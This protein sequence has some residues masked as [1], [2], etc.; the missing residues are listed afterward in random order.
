MFI[1]SNDVS[2]CDVIELYSPRRYDNGQFADIAGLSTPYVVLQ[3]LYSWGSFTMLQVYTAILLAILSCSAV[4]HGFDPLPGSGM[5]PD[6]KQTQ[7]HKETTTTPQ[8]A[9]TRDTIKAFESSL[10]KM[11]GLGSRPRPKGKLTI[12]Q[13]MMELYKTNLRQEISRRIMN[14]ARGPGMLTSNTVRSFYHEDDINDS[15]AA[16]ESI[17]LVFNVSSMPSYEVLTAAELRVYRGSPNVSHRSGSKKS[18]KVR[19]EVYD[20]IKP[21]TRFREAISRL[22]DVKGVDL[23]NKSWETFDIHSSVLKW[24]ESPHLNHG[25]EIRISP[26]SDSMLNEHVQKLDG[27]VRVR[28]SATMP[29]QQW[30]AER[31]LLVAYSDDGRGGINKRTRRSTKSD[32]KKRKRRQRRKRRRR[33]KRKNL[34]RRH[35]LY[36]DFSDVGWNDWIVAPPG[37]QAYYCH[38]DC[39]FTLADHLNSTNHAVVQTLVNSVNPSAV[40]KACCVATELSPISMLYLDEYDKVVLKNYQDMVVEGCGCR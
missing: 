36:V 16:G 29:R 17:N 15:Q 4:V 34:C 9:E 22:I 5:P 6:D 12:P 40:P 21:A 37:Y 20:I 18:Y 19:I 27:H 24:K 23:R 28:R 30:H 25:V 33:K 31:P 11:F 3:H 7:P 14:T 10:L 39:P 32:A 26:M 1:L 13:Y 2:T 35:P 8:D 38:G